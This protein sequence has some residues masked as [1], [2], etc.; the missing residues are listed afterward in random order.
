MKIGGGDHHVPPGLS[1]H[2]DYKGGNYEE[3]QKGDKKSEG[4][5]LLTFSMKSG[6]TSVMS[7]ATGLSEFEVESAMSAS[8]KK[9]QKPPSPKKRV[10]HQVENVEAGGYRRIRRRRRVGSY[11]EI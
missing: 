2:A 4:G 1:E 5:K 7:G 9:K 3:E 8:L 6:G 10:E 11:N